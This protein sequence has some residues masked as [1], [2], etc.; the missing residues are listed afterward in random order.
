MTET[1]TQHIEIYDVPPYPEPVQ[2]PSRVNESRGVY[3]TQPAVP[4][5]YAGLWRILAGRNSSVDLVFSVADLFEAQGI[6]GVVTGGWGLSPRVNRMFGIVTGLPA[7][8]LH[9]T[10]AARR[11]SLAEAQDIAIASLLEAEKRRQ[12]ERKREAVF[13]AGLED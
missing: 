3:V 8:Y 13:W 11:I 2:V 12:D 5:Y 10:R 6:G 4:R 9:T 7:T 1:L